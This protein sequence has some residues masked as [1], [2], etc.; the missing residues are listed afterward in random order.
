MPD[1]N[2]IRNG[3]LQAYK[4]AHEAIVECED[5]PKVDFDRLVAISECMAKALAIA[6]YRD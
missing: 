4:A 2:T 6:D 5:M 3:V 1:W